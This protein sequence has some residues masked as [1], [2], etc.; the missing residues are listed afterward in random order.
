MPEK[1]EPRLGL[2]NKKKNQDTPA[3]VLSESEIQKKLYGEFNEDGARSAVRDREHF[4]ESLGPVRAPAIA[5]EKAPPQDLF[6]V[7]KET[8][9]GTGPS[10]HEDFTQQKP[11][12]PSP[13]YIPLQEFERKPVAPSR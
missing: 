12:D 4:R 10:S 1:G 5:P 3:S 9:P 8:M 6:A 11:A 2:F 7:H 13:R